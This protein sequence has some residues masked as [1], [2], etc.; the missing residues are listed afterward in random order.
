MK[1]KP[2]QPITLTNR[3][4]PMAF[5][6]IDADD[7]NGGIIGRAT[8]QAWA[9]DRGLIHYRVSVVYN[10]K[11]CNGDVYIKALKRF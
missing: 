4:C 11:P 6:V 8:Y 10:G 1:L 2:A 5:D 7:P 3:G 9:T